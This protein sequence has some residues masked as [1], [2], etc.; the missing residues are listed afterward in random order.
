LRVSAER[1]SQNVDFRLYL[2]GTV[3]VIGGCF[4]PWVPHKTAALTVTGYELA[5]FAKFFPEVQGGVISIHRPLFYL[6]FV[7]ALLLVA[8]LAGRSTARFLRL[9]VPL[10]V[11]AVF[12]A[13]LLPYSV[14][15]GVRQ[16]LTAR[17][18][19]A[20]DPDVKR[21]L[22]LLIAAVALAA[23]A[24]LARRLSRRALGPVVASMALGG[25][26]PPL[27]QFVLLR[28][29]IVGLYDAPLAAGWGVIVCVAGAVVLVLSGI[30][31]VV[32]VG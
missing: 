21:Q 23:A 2:L 29:L 30:R 16:A 31:A 8:V 17:T 5:E 1:R 13:T 10:C 18:A 32:S 6:P 26:V 9:A 24:P 11:V 19:M 28:P 14:V 7:A 4:S 20:L 25:V 22:V 27:W 12:L 3:L 15:D